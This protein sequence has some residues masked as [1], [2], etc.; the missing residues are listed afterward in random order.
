MT[1]PSPDMVSPVPLAYAH[2]MTSPHPINE[3]HCVAFYAVAY[4]AH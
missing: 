2:A 4:L 3:V 1:L